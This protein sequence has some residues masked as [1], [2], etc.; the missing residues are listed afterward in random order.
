M[1]L[2][3]ALLAWYQEDPAW[4]HDTIASLPLAGVTTLV[5][6]DGAYDLF[7]GGQA[8]SPR[9]QREA[10]LQACEDAQIA[11]TLHSPSAMWAGGE[12]QKR[13]HLFTLG[14]AHTTPEDWYLIV[15]GD[16]TIISAPDDLHE[17]LQTTEHDA[18]Y[19]CLLNDELTNVAFAQWGDNMPAVLY[20]R[21]VWPLRCLFRA[22]RGL[23]VQGRHH[24]YITPDGRN[25]WG[26][27][28]SRD[29][30]AETITGLVIDH[31]RVHRDAS[32]RDATEAYY[33]TRN[34]ARAERPWQPLPA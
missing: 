5:A 23:K 13:S 31:R 19:G 17:R 25:L 30:P 29:A 33:A 24:D 26:D 14:E 28:T 4:L 7:P 27:N 9:E 21:Q 15:D 3:V 16:E 34:A 12:V 20:G 8:R 10:V 22:I 6:S 1:S 11:C 2:V 18:A 32:R